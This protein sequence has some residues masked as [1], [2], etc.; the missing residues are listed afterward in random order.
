MKTQLTRNITK[1][2]V[3]TLLISLSSLVKAADKSGWTQSIKAGLTNACIDSFQLSIKLRYEGVKGRPATEEE[4][5][6][7]DSAKPTFNTSCTC[8]INR[9]SS[10]MAYADIKDSLVEVDQFFMAVF[11]PSGSCA[12]NQQDLQTRMNNTLQ[13]MTKG[14]RVIN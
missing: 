5:R 13:A 11:K 10:Q 12:I 3:L 6:L 2:F 14:R 4:I 9:F 8:S 7:I 1:L